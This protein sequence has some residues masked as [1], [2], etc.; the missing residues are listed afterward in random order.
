MAESK[1]IRVRF[2]PSPTGYLHLGGART[3]LFNWIFAR[4]NNGTF[5][6]RIED[7]DRA[8]STGEANKAILE[9]LEWLG[10]NWDEGPGIG[11]SYGPYYQTERLDIYKDWAQRLLKEGKAYNCFCTPEEL[12]QKRSEAEARKEAPRYDG[13]CRKL[14]DAEI[15]RLRDSGKSCV[16]RFMLPPVGDTYVDDLVRGRVSFKNEL[17]DDFVIMKSDGF[18]TYNFAAVVDDS[19]MKITHVIRGD[20]HLSNT[21]RQILLYQAFGLP[22][23]LFAHIPMILGGDRARLSKRHGATSVIAYSELGYLPD[24]MVNYLARLGWGHGD[25]EVFT[26]EELIKYFSLPAVSKNPA[27][28]DTEKL[29]WLNGQYIRRLTSERFVELSLPY[30]EKVFPKVGD[31]LKSADGREYVNKAVSCLQDRIKV[32]PEIVHH[33]SY[34]FSDKIEY[35]AGDI[36]KY[37]NKDA[38]PVLSKLKDRLASLQKFDKP[39]I[40]RAFK[41]LA[42]ESTVKLGVVIHPARAALTG[43]AESPGIYD[44]VEILGM[45]ET[46]KRL[47][48]A[49]GYLGK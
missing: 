22:L 37:L 30:L 14:S 27:I 28:F 43:R 31:L 1:K 49:I 11:G 39:S 12:D 47:E 7:T 41:D 40:E 33:S 45:K 3:A 24:A 2:A 6:L 15:K 42:A 44:V 5:I 13:K 34:F 18:P 46:V 21:P 4:Q 26:R 16:T 36:Q 19:L 25:Q 23:P 10:L 32:F 48:E 35:D 9:G 38:I 20:D 17:L 29:N 8:R